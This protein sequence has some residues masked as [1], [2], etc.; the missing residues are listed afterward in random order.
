MIIDGMRD[1]GMY[2]P[3]FLGM[4]LWNNMHLSS[5]HNNVSHV[6][7]KLTTYSISKGKQIFIQNS[8]KKTV[9]LTV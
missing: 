2:I 1:A 4:L 3:L 9:G 7:L 6:Q 8:V 5:S